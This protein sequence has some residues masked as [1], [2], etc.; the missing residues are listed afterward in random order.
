MKKGLLFLVCG[1]LFAYGRAQYCGHFG[2]PSG[3]GQCNHHGVQA[4]KGFSPA[5]DSL[6]PFVNSIASTAVIQARF[7]DTVTFGG[8]TLTIQWTRIDSIGNLPAGLCWATDTVNNTFDTTGGCIKINGTPCDYPGQYKLN[9]I[10]TVNIGVSIQT[11]ADA[12]GFRYFF[13]LENQGDAEVPVDTSQTAA[14]PFIPYGNSYNC[15]VGVNESAIQNPQFAIFPNPATTQLNITIAEELIGAQLNIYDVTGA[16]VQTERLLTVGSQL[17]TGHLPPG[18]YIAEVN[19][20]A[21]RAGTAHPAIKRRWV[22][23]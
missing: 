11:N 4:P 2:N 5:Y 17:S 3:P 1:F 12:A 8:Q 20:P 15:F 19:P 21:G 16:L 7:G 14:N 22:K 18:I 6:P 23:M 13:R 9:I 10:L